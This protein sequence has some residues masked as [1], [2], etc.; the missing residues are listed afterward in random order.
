[1]SLSKKTKIG[2]INWRYETDK[3]D[4]MENCNERHFIELLEIKE[5]KCHRL[6]KTKQMKEKKRK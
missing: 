6:R 4:F 3:I 1:M 5:P 2:F